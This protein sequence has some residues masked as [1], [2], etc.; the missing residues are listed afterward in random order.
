VGALQ[1]TGRGIRGLIDWR[2]LDLPSRAASSRHLPIFSLENFSPQ[3]ARSLPAQEVGPTPATR[4]LCGVDVVLGVD[5]H[6]GSALG[7]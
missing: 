6:E 2:V 7:R 3:T 1:H 5:D 4:V